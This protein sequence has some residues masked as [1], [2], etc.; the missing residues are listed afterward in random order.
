MALYPQPGSSHA[1]DRS[2][3]CVRLCLVHLSYPEVA[4]RLV[5]CVR[6]LATLRALVPLGRSPLL[7]VPLEIAQ[8]SS[9]EVTARLVTRVRPLAAERCK[10]E[11]PGRLL[12]VQHLELLDQAPEEL[13]AAHDAG[14]CCRGRPPPTASTSWTPSSAWPDR[15][16]LPRTAPAR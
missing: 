13:P 7:V 2:P 3:L 4:A 11:R 1:C 14:P 9:S 6:P 15:G 16:I 10:P 8:L 12:V 5:A